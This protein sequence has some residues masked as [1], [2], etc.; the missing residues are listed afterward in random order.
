MSKIN[1][2]TGHGNLLC[3]TELTDSK[4]WLTQEGTGAMQLRK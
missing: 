2:G 1:G 4:R 3:M